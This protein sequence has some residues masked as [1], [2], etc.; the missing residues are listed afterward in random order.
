MY[1]E[2]WRSEVSDS[3]VS[4]VISGTEQNVK[5]VVAEVVERW[6]E[7]ATRRVDGD[8]NE[9]EALSPLG[10]EPLA[11]FLLVFGAHLAAGL[12]HDAIKAGIKAI[13]ARHNVDVKD[14]PKG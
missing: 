6:K 13:A 8:G 2:P 4:L 3:T 5:L 1:S 10:M 12:S 7:V 9:D 14:K 11:Y